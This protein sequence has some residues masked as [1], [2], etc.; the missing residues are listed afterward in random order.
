MAENS[1]YQF[2]MRTLMAF[3]TVSAVLFAGLRVFGVAPI[4]SLVLAA[5][6]GL[7]AVPVA[8]SMY[9]SIQ[10][11]AQADPMS[12]QVL[13]SVPD[14]VEAS[15]MVDEL[16]KEGIRAHTVGG[17]TSG[18]QI[19]VAGDVHVVVALADFERARE[20]LAALESE[21]EQDDS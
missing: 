10:A 5:A 8:L 7:I 3:V 9:R 19:Q 17:F 18:F 21:W 6:F 20:V 13:A 11:S 1:Q 16:E 15:M 14:E 12:P 4:M 2:S